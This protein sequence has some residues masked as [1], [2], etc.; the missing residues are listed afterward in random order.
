MTRRT[1]QTL[2][3][4]DCRIGYA[5]G[6]QAKREPK[7]DPA[8]DGISRP[9]RQPSPERIHGH[10]R[11]ASSDRR[12][13]VDGGDRPRESLL[14]HDLLTITSAI[15]ER[16][17][18]LR[19]REDLDAVQASPSCG[20]VL[21]KIALSASPRP[22]RGSTL[23]GRGGLATLPRSGADGRG[24]RAA[25]RRVRERADSSSDDSHEGTAI[26]RRRPED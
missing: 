2:S 7:S 13:L 21:T 5:G 19:C 23:R 26:G 22:T 18:A 4:D 25:L 20:G 6:S 3:W 10:R 14:R 9:I 11:H 16:A 17:R 15:F 12:R 24:S 1:G 8:A